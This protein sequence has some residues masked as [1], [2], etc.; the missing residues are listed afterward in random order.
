MHS[1]KVFQKLASLVDARLRCEQNGNKEWRFRHTCAIEILA[2]EYLPRGSG[3]D[4]DTTVDLDASTGEKLVLR[5]S[6]HH[7][8]EHGYEGWTEHTVTVRPSFVFTLDMKI[9][10]RNRN[11]IKDYMHDV[12]HDALTLEYRPEDHE[13]ASA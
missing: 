12:F 10:G 7:H 2:K 13:Q 1:T 5:T 4:S 9:S 6:F 11:E 3:F 8:G